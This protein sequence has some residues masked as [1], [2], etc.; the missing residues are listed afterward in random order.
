M[1]VSGIR[2]ADEIEVQVRRYAARFR[3]PLRRLSE[4]SPAL[5]DL[6][7]SFPAA[8]LALVTART[9]PAARAQ[10]RELVRSGAPLAD[11]ACVLQLPL[12]LRRLPPEAF[13]RVL[14]ARIGDGRDAEF[15]RRVINLMPKEGKSPAGWLHWV[16]AARAVCGDEFALWLA[17]QPIFQTRRQPPPNALLP[18]AMFAWFSRHP[19]LAAAKLMNARW[20]AKMGIERAAYLTRRWLHRVLQDLCLALPDSRSVWAQARHVSGF[21]FVPLLTSD[22][23]VEEGV[24]MHNCLA[25]Y[26][27]YVVHGV[28]RLY[29][30]RCNGVSVATM[31]VRNIQRTTT[32]GIAQLLARSNSKAPPEVHEA[33]RIWLA[34]QL[35]ESCDAEAFNWGPPTDAAFQ[36][37]VWRPYASMLCA[38]GCGALRPPTVTSLLRD[39]GA[40]CV[41]EK[42]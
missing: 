4:T 28:C 5:A 11:V 3:R 35:Q 29:S 18:L 41:L 32:P 24:R 1:R 40:L 34:L 36:T 37:H 7:F 14:P 13:D 20:T 12:W 38:N 26:S 25:T 6:L 19:E 23:L 39:I 10:A 42:H 15:G 33:A 21:D 27:I 22:Q 8:C 31:D 16:L 17:A 2:N 30:V 9:S